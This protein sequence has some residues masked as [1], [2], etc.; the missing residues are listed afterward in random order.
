MIDLK[1]STNINILMKRGGR[2]GEQG[3]DHCYSFF[4]FLLVSKIYRV[5]TRTWDLPGNPPTPLPL[6]LGLKGLTIAIH[7]SNYLSFK[8]IKEMASRIRDNMEFHNL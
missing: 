6:E 5:K 3:T 2:K 1:A 4:F 7:V 8:V